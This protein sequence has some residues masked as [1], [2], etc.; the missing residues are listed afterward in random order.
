MPA[1]GSLPF[2]GIQ[3]DYEFPLAVIFANFDIRLFYA[4]GLSRGMSD[5]DA[6]DLAFQFS[7]L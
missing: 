1:F 5:S 2:R 4:S 7:K 3:K 6:L